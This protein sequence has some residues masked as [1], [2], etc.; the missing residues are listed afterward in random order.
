MPRAWGLVIAFV[1]VLLLGSLWVAS[2]CGGGGTPSGPQVVLFASHDR[3]FSEPIVKEFEKATGIRVKLVTDA[4]A[5]KTVG[6]VNRLLSRKEH[7]EADVFWNNEIAHT[8][9]LREAGLLEAYVA[10]SAQDIPNAYKDAAGWW[11]GFGARARVLLVNTDLLPRDQWPSKVEDLADPRL[12]GKVAIARPLFGTTLTHAAALY[13]KLGPEKAQAFFR[14]LKANEVKVAA[15]NALARDLVVNGEVACCLTD[16]DDAN[17]AL[18]K[19]APVVMLYP[20]QEG[21]GALVIPNTVAL[22]K[23]GPNP[24]AARKLVDFLV[25]REVETALARGPAAQLPV[26]PG[27]PTHGASFDPATFKAMEVDWEK[28]PRH[29]PALKQFVQDELAW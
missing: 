3:L 14:A 27:V 8:L 18:L 23:G 10:P 9:I 15:G 24:E 28:L 6:L 17:G 16:T 7:P 11:T 12:R 1:S 26:R 25:S 20:D 22:I 21:V 4:E 13:E 2:G 5:A 19:G 29:F